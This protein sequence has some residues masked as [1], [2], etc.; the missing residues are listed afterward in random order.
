LT[1]SHKFLSIPRYAKS[2]SVPFVPTFSFQSFSFTIKQVLSTK[3]HSRIT[4]GDS[5]KLNG[6]HPLLSIAHTNMRDS[7]LVKMRAIECKK[8]EKG[9]VP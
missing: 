2:Y 5:F 8:H 6:T 1:T 7:L 9:F 3:P 4:Y